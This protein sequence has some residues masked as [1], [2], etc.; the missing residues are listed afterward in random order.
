MTIWGCFSHPFNTTCK[1]WLTAHSIIDFETQAIMRSKIEEIIINWTNS[2]GKQQQVHRHTHTQRAWYTYCKAFR[3]GGGEDCSKCNTSSKKELHYMINRKRIGERVKH[4]LLTKGK[5]VS[6]DNLSKL[7][8][9][10]QITKMFFLVHL[11]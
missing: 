6:F 3:G 11:N 5:K 4:F 1:I 2:K 8:W 7:S 9:Q 10:K